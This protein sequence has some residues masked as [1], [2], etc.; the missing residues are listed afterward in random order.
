M[1]ATLRARSPRGRRGFSLPELMVVVAVGAVLVL[2]LQQALIGQRRYYAAQ[3]AATQRHETVRVAMAVLSGAL[4]EINLANGDAAILSPGRLRVRIPLG[5]GVVCG[6]DASGGRI[7]VA[8]AEGR[9]TAEPGDSVLLRR[10]GGWSPE[11]LASVGAAT[12]AVPCLAT[13]GTEVRLDRAAPDVVA[14]SAARTFR[15]VVFEVAAEGGSHGLYRID[16]ARTELL[17]GPLSGPEGFRSWYEDASGTE[18]ADPALAH[19]IGVRIVARTAEGPQATGT[20]QDTLAL[21]FGGRNR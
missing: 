13:G 7:G 1:K 2:A 17:A 12:P 20:R 19:R 16:G 15:S 8:A 9:W 4:R 3:R 6:T 11:M 5:S 21:T 10:G 18:V 14:G